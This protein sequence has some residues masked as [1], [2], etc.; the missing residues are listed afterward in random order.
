MGKEKYSPNVEEYLEELYRL[1]EGGRKAVST[2]ELAGRLG[3]KAPSVTEMLG[4][5]SEEGLVDYEPYMGAEL[6]EDGVEKGRRLVEKHRLVERLLTDVLGLDW[7]EVHEEA[8]ELEH[9][10]SEELE[11]KIREALERPETCPHGN[12]VS[13]RNRDE[14]IVH[15]PE[16]ARVL[17]SSIGDDDPALLHEVES[18][19][20]LPG[21]EVEIAERLPDG[22]TVLRTEEGELTLDPQHSE[23]V[24]GERL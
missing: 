23:K 24:R 6:T 16:G 5:L 2:G 19:G 7:S 17:V 12:P 14:R 13:G 4:N 22:S 8:C 11:E 3:V 9:A 1:S 18:H 10:I 20:V 21:S 15:F